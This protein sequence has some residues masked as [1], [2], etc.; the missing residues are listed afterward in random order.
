MD[1]WYKKQSLFLII[2]V[3]LLVVVAIIFAWKS[4]DDEIKTKKKY[5]DV[6]FPKNVVDE[7]EYTTNKK[8]EKVKKKK[9]SKFKEDLNRLFND[10]S[11]AKK[12]SDFYVRAGK[13]GNFKNLVLDGIKFLLFGVALFFVFYYLL[14]NALIAGMVGILV[15]IMPY[16]AL[17]SK[18]Q[19]RE[20]QFRNTFPY[21]LQ[22]VAFV[23]K[24]GTNF[25]SAFYEVVHKQEEGVLKE[26][27]LEVLEIRNI[28]SG[29][30]KVAF[31]HITEKMKIEEASDFVNVVIDNLTKGTSIA[32]V[33][34]QQAH[35]TTKI[36]DLNK[37]KKISSASTKIL[38]PILVMV[39]SIAILFLQMF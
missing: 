35:S 3:I 6:V 39:M 1:E 8:G 4:I 16:V 23:L 7:T 14:K 15:I 24:N 19:A 33:F 30:D 5:S 36:L 2:G 25:S 29:D 27:M 26:I 22:T 21:F 31:K 20:K 9:N 38:L 18:V 17:Y 37:K 11:V 34:L 12:V 13:D 28:N 32:D 10:S